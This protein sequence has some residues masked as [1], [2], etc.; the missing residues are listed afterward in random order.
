MN[1]LIRIIPRYFAI[2]EKKRLRLRFEVVT[3]DS[4]AI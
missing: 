2:I 4:L 1:I 3:V